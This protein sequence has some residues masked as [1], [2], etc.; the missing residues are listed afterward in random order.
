M[1]FRPRPNRRTFLLHCATSFAGVCLG[2][3]VQAAE[4]VT[5][6]SWETVEFP[7]RPPKSRRLMKINASNGAAGYSR[8]CATDLKNAAA[9]AGDANLLDHGALW[10]R[11]RAAGVP[12]SEIA[13]LDIAAWDLHARMLGKPLHSLLGTK[14]TKV[15]RY[16]DVRG[17]QPGFAPQAYADGV[18]RYLERT[19]LR[20][21]KLHFPGAMGTPES[22]PF[23]TVLD[24]LRAVRRAVG[25]DAILAWDP[26][27]GSAESATPSVDEA[28]Q[29]LALMD[30]LGY[31]WI[32]GPL[33]PVPFETQIPK[34][35]ELVKSG[36]KLRIQA[37]G[38]GS[39]VGDGTGFDD[40]KRWTDAGAITQCSTD[41]YIHTGVTNCLRILEYARAHPPLVVNL[42]WAWAPHA[43]LAM[44]SDEA[45]MPLVEF[46]MGEDVPKEFMSGPWLLAPDWPGIYRID[47]G[48]ERG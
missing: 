30:E 25:A 41:A 18:A 10:E 43:H 4:S 6:G 34:Y 11:L 35:A 40:M 38:P 17:Q 8:A 27:P 31:A 33:P 19:G 9:A 36:A 22:V 29:I 45:T 23:A 16:G 48:Q 32:E 13:T 46:P 37:E 39:P 47:G 44:A 1:R 42:H 26:Y 2:P 5:L 15:L 20:A 21:T 12:K 3:R 24:T 7:G 28:K 14:R